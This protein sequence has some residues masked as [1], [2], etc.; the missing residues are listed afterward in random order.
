[1]A[2][3]LVQA[4]ATGAAVTRPTGATPLYL[5]S[6]TYTCTTAAGLLEIRDGAGGAN[7]IS[8]RCL[9]DQTMLWRAGS[10]PEGVPFYTSIFI[11]TLGGTTP[12]VSIE[13][14]NQ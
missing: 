13:Y 12:V 7:L 1:M 5:K 11:Q 8:M 9:A 14:D 10:Q 3:Q 4:T 2:A 6:V